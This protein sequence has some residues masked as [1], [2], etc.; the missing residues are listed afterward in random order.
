MTAQAVPAPATAAAP[1]R[2]L[3]WGWA[4]VARK[5]LS[6]QL[7][8]LRFGA[9]LVVLGL[10]AGA[11]VYSA[12]GGISEVAA[13]QAGS[14]GL[15]LRLFTVQADPIP[16][17]FYAFIGFLAPLLGIALGFDA[18]NGERAQRTLPRLVAQPIHR[19]DVI[20][21]K[22][23]AGLI[24]VTALLTTVTLV[25]AGLGILRLGIVPTAGEVARLAVWLAG[26]ICYVGVW[27]ALALLLSVVVSRAST[28]ALVAI[29]LWLVLVIFGSLLAGLAAG[30]LAPEG[31][32]AP[33]A[34]LHHAKVEKTL[35][36]FSTVTLY[37]ESTAALLNPQVRFV[38]VITARQISQAIPTTLSVIQ[39]V[40][41]VWP[42]LVG[43]LAVMVVCFAI[44]Y[45][46]FMGQEIRA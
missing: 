10:A 21:G 45:L 36:R 38:G 26:A 1:P 2:R 18:I 15:F 19:D 32:G 7:L 24:T 3:G 44:A 43:M 11:A 13:Q 4:V 37:D 35:E 39:S 40:L 9:L 23:L 46:E 28:S 14:P 16:F 42:Q 34:V 29:A 30:V 6:D 33:A 22:F 12:G 17:S 25:V 31:D 5:E 20:N 27:L 8:S 41:L